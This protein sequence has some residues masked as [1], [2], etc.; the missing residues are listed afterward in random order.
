MNKNS[1]KRAQLTKTERGKTTCHLLQCRLVQEHDQSLRF[2]P[3]RTSETP[4]GLSEG[5]VAQAQAGAEG[6]LS[7]VRPAAPRGA[8]LPSFSFN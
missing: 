8:H 1:T 5:N 6:A 7:P 4:H 2:S 3:K